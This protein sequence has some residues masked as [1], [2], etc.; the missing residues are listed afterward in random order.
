[1]PS[2]GTACAFFVMANPHADH[3]VKA[4]P[5]LSAAGTCGAR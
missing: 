2:I 3:K 1:L 5:F 4:L